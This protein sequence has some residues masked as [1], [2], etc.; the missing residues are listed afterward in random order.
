MKKVFKNLIIGLFVFLFGLFISILFGYGIITEYENPTNSLFRYW[1]LSVATII[2]LLN[3]ICLILLIKKSRKTIMLLNV[4]YSLLLGLV[5]FGFVRK[6]IYLQIETTDFD[7]GFIS[8]SLFILVFL[9]F[10]INKFKYLEIQYENIEE[11]GKHND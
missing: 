8:T 2:F 7:L 11:I 6:K 3:I 4:F 9:I 5:L 10:I 1:V